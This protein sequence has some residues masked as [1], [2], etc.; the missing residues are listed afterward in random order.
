MRK[1]GLVAMLLMAA[2]LLAAEPGAWPQWR[3]SNGNGV[4]AE[5]NWNPRCLEGGAKVL[6]T[7]DIGTGYSNVAISGGRLYAV[8]SADSTHLRFCCLD[9]D[10]GQPIWAQTYRL[11]H[12]ANDPMS[13]P[14]VDG[15]RLYAMASNGTVLCLG[16][17][18]GAVRWKKWLGNEPKADVMVLDQQFGQAASPIVANSAG[19]ALDKMSGELAWDSG[20]AGEGVNT[21]ASPTLARLGGTRVAMFL[22]PACLSA[23]EAATGRLLWSIPH[24]EKTEIIADPVTDGHL[25]F[26]ATTTRSSVIDPTEPGTPRVLWSR[27]CLRSDAA[28]PVLANGYLFGTDWMQYVDPGN[29]QV[30]KR[31]EWPFQCVDLETG[32]VAWTVTMPHA[33]LIAAGGKL[34]ILDVKGTLSV[35]EANPREFGVI[36]S[37]DVLG[38]ASRP[39][40]FATP[41]VLCDGRI[42]VRNYAGDLIC[43]D[44]RK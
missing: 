42:Y 4:S 38:G 22:G 14:T 34:I 9:A 5:A 2:G 39:R 25:V 36:S 13:T 41:P 43:I 6:W 1:I 23:V 17:E 19:I 20:I 31:S 10:S 11:G 8:G 21:Y 24:L 32:A 29:W 44:A 30:L 18:D 28:T 12:G 3:G 37:A 15:D 16:T 33:S 26:F 27:E 40:V 35:A 7:A